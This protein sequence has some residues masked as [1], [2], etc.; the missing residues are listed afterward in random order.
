M[1]HGSLGH[2]ETNMTTL[3]QPVIVIPAYNRQQALERLL[4]T[5]GKAEYPTVVKLFISLEGGASDVVKRVAHGFRST[6]LDVEIIER[7][8]RL[9]LREHIL[10]CGDLALAYGAVI[11]LEDDLL[12][13]RYF[14]H[15]ATAALNHY[16]A[17]ESVAGI[18]LYS[19]ERNEYAE[20]PFRPMG[21]GYSTY[22]MQVPCS[23]GQGWTIKQWRKFRD[24]Y[25]TADSTTVDETV[26]LPDAVKKWP[27]SSWKKYFAAY[28]VKNNLNFIYPYQ[29][30]STNCSDP[31][32]AHM[33]L[34]SDFHQTSFASQNRPLPSFLFCP[35]IDSEVAY[36]A[37]MEPCGMYVYRALGLSKEQVE[38]DTLGIKSKE[39]LKKEYILTCRKVSKHIHGYPRNYRPT[40]HNLLYPVSDKKQKVFSLSL[41]KDVL[42]LKRR[43]QRTAD[44]SYASG[45]NLDSLRVLFVILRA[46]PRV[47]YERVKR[48]FF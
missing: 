12:I 35:S 21:N 23:W 47:I 36:D 26:G 11:V 31:G 32:G 44:Y 5:V 25:A 46:A 38:I 14:Y 20:L 29:T 3:I 27:K 37:F 2:F 48:R 24:W 1:E 40:E 8:E 7:P 43:R 30:Y 45:I 17:D 41:R 13:D 4:E 42:Q 39:I 34:G 28:L 10:N 15:Y 9:G 16:D 22:P 6:K 18:A 19:L 33:A